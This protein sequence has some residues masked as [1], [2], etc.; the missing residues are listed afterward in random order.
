MIWCFEIDLQMFILKDVE[1]FKETTNKSVIYILFWSVFK[2]KTVHIQSTD[3]TSVIF[4]VY[5]EYEN[6][7]FK[8]EVRYLSAHKKHDHVINANNENSS[9]RFLYNVLDKELQIL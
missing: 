3:I 6:V 4:S 9:Y 5:A 8:V 7:F 1:S 2:V